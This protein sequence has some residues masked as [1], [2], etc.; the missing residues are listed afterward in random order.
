[1]VTVVPSPTA[2]PTP[3]PTPD[4]TAEDLATIQQIIEQYWA[5]FNDY[6]AD[7]A[8]SMLEENYRAAEEEPIRKD[9]GR[10]KLFRVKL[11]I[12]EE[13]PLTLQENGDYETYLSIKTPIDTRRVQMVFRRIEGEWWIVFSDVVE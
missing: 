3:T 12:S 4:T 2:Q 11:G 5:A 1:M 9:I 6:D 8:I 13:T 7:H 10:M